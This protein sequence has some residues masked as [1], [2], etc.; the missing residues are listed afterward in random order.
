MATNLN[1]DLHG[2]DT[3]DMS[4]DLDRVPRRYDYTV[5]ATGGK[6]KVRI[7][8]KS[9]DVLGV[10]ADFEKGKWRSLVEKFDTD[11]GQTT[12]GHFTLPAFGDNPLTRMRV[13]FSRSIGTQ[14]VNYEFHMEP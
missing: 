8:V 2:T 4:A 1:G 9:P 7:D 5:H 12:S 11:S 14:G 3:E 10:G 6:V 13:H